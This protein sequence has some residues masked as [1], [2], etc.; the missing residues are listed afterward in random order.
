MPGNTK[1][2]WNLGSKSFFGSRAPNKVLLVE[3][4]SQDESCQPSMLREP[5]QLSRS[6]VSTEEKGGKSRAARIRQGGSKFFS[7]VGVQTNSETPLSK[8][9]SSLPTE[10]DQALA[11]SRDAVTPYDTPL[12]LPAVQNA[13]LSPSS[14]QVH[15]TLP[16]PLT[17]PQVSIHLAASVWSAEEVD[18]QHNPDVASLLA[19]EAYSRQKEPFGFRQSISSAS[20]AHR[21]S[22]KLSATFGNPTIVHRPNLRP[23]PSL[24]SMRND[25]GINK[26]SQ[27]QLNS[28]EDSTAPSSL[29]YSGSASAGGYSTG[30]TSLDSNVASTLL[31][32]HHEILNKPGEAMVTSATAGWEKS[33]APIQEAPPD[34]PSI[35]TVETAANAKIFFETHY[36]PLLAGKTSPRSLRR[37]ELECRLDAQDVPEEY[38]CCERLAWAKHESYHLRQVRILKGKTNQATDNLGMTVAGYEIVRILGKGSFGI[39]R[40]VREKEP[41]PISA[42][43][44]APIAYQAWQQPTHHG[45]STS[46]S[47]GPV[48]TFSGPTSP[49]VGNSNKASREVYAMKVI[50]KSDMLR[51]CQEGHLR[52]ERDFLVASEKSMWVVPLVASFQDRTNLYLVM[53]YMIGGD[54]LGLLF[55]RNIL[56]ERHARWYIA[57]M[58]LCVEETHRRNWIHRDIKPDNFLISSSGH[59]KISDFGLAFDGHWSHDQR[60]YKNHRRNLMDKLGIEIKGDFEDQQEEAKR[61][62]RGHML[63]ILTGRSIQ[64]REN[65]QMEEAGEDESILQWRNRKGKRRMAASVVGTSQYMAPEVIRGDPYD[66]RCDWWSIGIILYE[67]L[68]GFTPFVCEKRE[69]TKARILDN[70]NSLMFPNAREYKVSREAIDLIGNLLQEKEHRLSSKKYMFNDYQ[71]SRRVPGQLISKYADLSAADY[72]GRFVYPNDATDIKGHPFFSRIAWDRHHLTRPPFVPDT[73]GREDTKYFDEEDPIS[74]VDDAASQSSGHEGADPTPACGN[75]NS[76]ALS[77]ADKAA[78]G[79]TKKRARDKVL[80]DEEVGRQALE[81]RKKGAFIGYTYRRPKLFLGLADQSGRQQ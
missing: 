79:R 19:P 69:D 72:K 6:D 28:P 30:K 15:Q 39:V 3:D 71:H 40:L 63:N 67:C 33:L 80:R 36:D 18:E 8:E 73:S 43:R 2:K 35:V 17:H 37:R 66:G 42:A 62:S 34:T 75:F 51:N 55:R 57:E 68:Y 41:I 38:R 60:F 77:R 70:R 64:I 26:N 44:L 53:E 22:H 13:S 9:T 58:I 20:I 59:L 56:K 32:L 45:P 76:K 29:N 50:R 11:I 46:A 31:T 54:F 27:E 52:A 7:I 78:K 21:L 24:L 4:T 25:R 23:R 48:P 1:R 14:I 12:P 74:D 49:R 61:T 65:A 16:S 81:L 5:T 47:E 10:R